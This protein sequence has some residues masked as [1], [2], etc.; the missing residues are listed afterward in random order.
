MPFHL[1]DQ[2]KNRGVLIN[3]FFYIISSMLI[4]VIFC[5]FVFSLKVSLQEKKLDDLK[6]KI[7]SYG[8]QEQKADEKQVLDYKKKIED[9]SIILG[10]HK[11][12]SNVFRF[13]EDKTLSNV[14]FSNF[15]M[16]QSTNEIRL[17]G[18]AETME[19][20]SQQFRMFEESKEYVKQISVLNSQILPNGKASFILSI[21]L[22][23]SIFTSYVRPSAVQDVTAITNPAN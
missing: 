3:Y 23:P 11:I 12:S 7:A 6:A 8:T 5:Y 13:I 17:A 18:E 10:N 14:W 4:A 20:L 1:P 21:I 9:F 2:F 15:D 19:V 16:S 22:Y